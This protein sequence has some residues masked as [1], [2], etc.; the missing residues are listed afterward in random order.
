M[1][2]SIQNVYKN[3]IGLQKEPSRKYEVAELAAFLDH[4]SCQ[5]Q[6]QLALKI[7]SESAS[8]YT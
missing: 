8:N 1:F 4:D 7:R 6:Q 5:T 3:F 2:K